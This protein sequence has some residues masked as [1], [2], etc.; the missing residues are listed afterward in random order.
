MNSSAP[1]SESARQAMAPRHFGL[2][3]SLK[4]FGA[5]AADTARV[6]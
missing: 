5:S 1:I 4:F 2:S 3:R 6:L